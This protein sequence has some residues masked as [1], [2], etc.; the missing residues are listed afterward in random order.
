MAVLKYKDGNEWKVASKN[1]AYETSDIPAPTQQ[2]L[3]FGDTTAYTDFDFSYFN[4][5]G[6]WDWFITKY[7]DKIQLKRVRNCSY[8][9]AYSELTSVP[10][11]INL[12]S[13]G[14][15]STFL[16]ISYVI[17]DSKIQSLDNVFVLPTDSFKGANLSSCFYNAKY[18][19]KIPAEIIEL[20]KLENSNGG[21][22]LIYPN[23]FSYCYALDEITGLGAPVMSGKMTSNRFNST[24]IQ[25]QH[26]KHL[27]FD[28]NQTVE[29]KNQTIDLT[30]SVGYGSYI[31]MYGFSTSKKITDDATYESLKDDPDSW[32]SD[33]NYSRYNRIS[34]V[35]TINS[36]PDTS[37]YLATAGGTNTIKFKG[38][39]GSA[40]DGGAINTMTEEEIAVATAKGWTVSFV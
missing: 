32:T 17:R 36:L 19:R 25:C 30:S 21:N 16:T 35:E 11:K 14:S 1:V 23:G 40:T 4:Y 10:I 28:P 12:S 2:E 6:I 8:M 31:E 5:N 13:G 22:N 18:L 9:F 27:T 15:S 39:Q 7:K 34:A 38:A 24:F 33:I 3:T 29:W 20:T 37:A 26:L